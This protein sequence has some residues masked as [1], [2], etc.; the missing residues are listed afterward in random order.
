MAET[1]DEFIHPTDAFDE[2]TGL[3]YEYD[4]EYKRIYTLYQLMYTKPFTCSYLLGQTYTEELFSDNQT[5]FTPLLVK[6]LATI[7]YK[8]NT[9]DSSDIYDLDYEILSIK[10]ESDAN[11]YTIDFGI[12]NFYN[13]PIGSYTAHLTKTV[14][15]LSQINGLT[16]G[17]F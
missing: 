3:Y 4:G 13:L 11:V 1:D 12:N 8:L 5:E 9:N 10:T 6:N 7:K 16:N 15:H 14:E 17:A 2:K